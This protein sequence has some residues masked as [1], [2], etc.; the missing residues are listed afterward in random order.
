MKLSPRRARLRAGSSGPSMPRM[1]ARHAP[2]GSLHDRW[3]SLARVDYLVRDP[4][5]WPWVPVR[6]GRDVSA[7][8]RIAALHGKQ[9]FKVTAESQRGIRRYR[10]AHDDPTDGS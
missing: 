4:R 5:A 9:R 2:D 3:Q 8:T 10:R 7:W 6:Q 1:L